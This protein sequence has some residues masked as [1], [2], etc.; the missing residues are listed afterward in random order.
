MLRLKL[1]S[2]PSMLEH[3]KRSLTKPLVGMHVSGKLHTRGP[4]DDGDRWREY[5]ECST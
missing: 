1:E 2:H 4:D 5:R 3:V